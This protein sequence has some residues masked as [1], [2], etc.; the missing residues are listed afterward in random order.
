MIY[1]IC[2][3]FWRDW[4]VLRRRMF[5][6]ILSRM[7]TPILYLVAFGWGRGRMFAGGDG[8]YLDFIVPGI[9][10]LNSMNISFNAVGSPLNISRLFYKTFDEYLIAPISP[11]AFVLGKV[12]AGLVKGLLSSIVM[13][14]VALIFKANIVVNFWFVLVIIMNCIIFAAIAVVA[15]LKMNSHEDM[16]NC[17]TYILL[18]MSFL[19][20]TFFAAEELPTALRWFIELLPLTHTSLLLRSIASTGYVSIYSVSILLL[21]IIG[22]LLLA[23]KTVID[24]KE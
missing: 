1:D 5:R 12:L 23:V 2:T 22:A 10:A 6:F 18:P 15:A 21:Y 16:N 14:G 4:L 17:N 11:V 8:N 13:I 3:I 20:G 9:I 7:I 24:C 19:C